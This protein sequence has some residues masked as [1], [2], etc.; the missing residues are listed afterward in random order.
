MGPSSITTASILDN[1]HIFS[2]STCPQR[3]GA[4]WGASLVA[5]MVKTLPAVQRPRANPWISG[6]PQDPL[7]EGMATHSSILFFFFSNFI[8]F[9]NFT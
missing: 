1:T 9:L 2:M 6:D 5:Q 3:V 7:E 8:L 4:I